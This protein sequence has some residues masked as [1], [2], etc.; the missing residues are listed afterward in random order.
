M[1]DREVGNMKQNVVEGKDDGG[2]WGDRG[3]R[4]VRERVVRWPRKNLAPGRSPRRS[5]K[6]GADIQR[7]IF[8]ETVM[9]PESHLMGPDQARVLHGLQMVGDRGL[10]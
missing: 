2:Q 5:S 6:K 8:R 1:R 9:D 10:A 7:G 4:V 3:G